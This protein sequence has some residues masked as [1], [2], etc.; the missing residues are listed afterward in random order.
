MIVSGM[1]G[2]PP[3]GVAGRLFRPSVG[4]NFLSSMCSK[5]GGG[6]GGPAP[7]PRPAPRVK[8]PNHKH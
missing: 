8:H 5:A 4:A 7:A 3:G 6:G 1:V 2:P